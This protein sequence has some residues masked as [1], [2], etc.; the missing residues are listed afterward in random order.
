MVGIENLSIGYSSRVVN[1]GL[2]GTLP[3]GSLTALVGPNGVG[4]STLLRT[5]AGLLAPLAGRVAVQGHDF[6]SYSL[7]QRSHLLA[8]VLTHR[9]GGVGL[10][11]RDVVEMGRMPH[12]G[13]DGRLSVEDC[14]LVN[15]SLEAAGVTA[16]SNR[17]IDSLSDGER[18]RVMIAKALA[19]STPVILLDEPTAFLDFPA[20]VS[21]MRLLRTLS[22]EKGKTILL[23]THDL[24]LSFQTVDRLWL[25]SAEG[26]EEGS[27][28]ALAQGGRLERCF[29]SADCR[30][31]RQQMRFVF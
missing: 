21:V 23:S 24:E 20:K 8:V 1:S 25:L 11:V 10:T 16:L 3:Q 15:E 12:T 22:E 5:L 6:H 30:F 14:D 27:P 18:Q 9:I 26:L 28:V 2:S 7:R 17:H 13:F 19:Q 4:K 31:D 29:R